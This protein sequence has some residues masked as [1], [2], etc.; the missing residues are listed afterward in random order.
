MQLYN[1]WD[2]IRVDYYMASIVEN[3]SIRVHTYTEQGQC[4]I[5]ELKII[6]SRGGNG[7]Q[8]MGTIAPTC[9]HDK[10][11]MDNNYKDPLITAWDDYLLSDQDILGQL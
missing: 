9:I 7:A 10:Q 2:W 4:Q 5:L 11:N 6:F 8:V 1:F 3:A